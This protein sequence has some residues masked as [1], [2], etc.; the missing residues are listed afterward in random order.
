MMRKQKREEQKSEGD[1]KR[2]LEF[3]TE[4]DAKN[5]LPD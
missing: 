2:V 3:F 1:Q 5:D 4:T